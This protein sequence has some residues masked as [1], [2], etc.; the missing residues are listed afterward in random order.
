[1]DRWTPRPRLITFDLDDTL[2]DT[3]GTLRARI[4]DALA[5]AERLMGGHWLAA[6]PREL[7]Q[8]EVERSHDDRFAPVLH[9]L[10]L[11]R[12]HALAGELEASYGARTLE[13]LRPVAGAVSTLA[14][15]S[16]VCLIAVITNGDAVLQRTKLEA[17]GLAPYVA[18]VFASSELGV[19]KPA[20]AIFEAACAAFDVPP[21]AALHVGDAPVTDALGA[22]G[23]GM[24]A[25]LLKTLVPHP[26]AE[27][28][29]G[30]V[31]IERLP[32]LL[33]LM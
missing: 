1:M 23:A 3:F 32:D 9:A 16:E 33:A 6:T 24:R 19:R 5:A 26:D 25:V 31:R 28:L 20:R 4:D 30:V 27:G 2:V 10:G 15:L 11:D 21:S 29:D 17:T 22:L 12:T 13:L 8:N 7:L 14:A 18:R